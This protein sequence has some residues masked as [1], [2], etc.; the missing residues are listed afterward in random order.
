MSKVPTNTIDPL[1]E[2][3]SEASVLSSSPEF[4]A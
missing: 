4:R 3:L 2:A 1:T